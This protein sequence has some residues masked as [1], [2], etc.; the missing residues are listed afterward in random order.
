MRG[1]P[2]FQGKVARRLRLGSR[3]NIES[4]VEP[5]HPEQQPENHLASHHK[6]EFFGNV[7]L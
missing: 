5:L 3:V 2:G 7:E 6:G 1:R 4:R